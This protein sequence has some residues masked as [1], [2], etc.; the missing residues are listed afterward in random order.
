LKKYNGVFISDVPGLGKTY[1]GAALLS[2]LETEGKPA[3]VV[4]PPRLV[5]YRRDILANFGASKARVISSG[6]IE[7]A[8]ENESYLKKKVVLVDESHHFRNPETKRYRDLA[9]ICEGKEVIL[10]S[11]TPQNLNIWDIYWQLK[12]FTPY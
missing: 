6:K 1:I 10:V 5:E 12:L 9:K 2:H 3:L 4:A 11:A 7:E 8:F